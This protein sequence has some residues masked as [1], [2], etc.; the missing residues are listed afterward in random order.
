MFKNI[1]IP[2]DGSPASRRAIAAGVQMAKVMGAKVTG[3]FAAPAATP[4]V[5]RHFLPVGYSTPQAHAKLIAS[6]AAQYLAVIEAAA[7]KSGV[8]CEVVTV[9][10][11]FPADAILSVAKKKE[12]DL[13]VMATHGRKGIAGA[14]I[15][16]E[17]Q[18]VL[19]RSTIPVLACR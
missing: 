18:K 11:D 7:K 9:T 19:I 16:S 8:K 10:N 4:V 14:L 5:Y 1:L 12:C 15:G 17:T 3:L 6:T 13:I 2:T